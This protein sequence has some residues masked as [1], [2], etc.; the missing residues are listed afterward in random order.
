MS[1][2]EWSV[3]IGLLVLVVGAFEILRVLGK[4]HETLVDRLPEQHDE[5][6][7]PL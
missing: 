3:V 6:E 2:F 7:E 4:I 5:V 1:P